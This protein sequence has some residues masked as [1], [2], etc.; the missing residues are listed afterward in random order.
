MRK[1]IVGILILIAALAVACDKKT[2][3]AEADLP[4]VEHV[5]AECPTG[6]VKLDFNGESQTFN[7]IETKDGVFWSAPM[8]A[9]VDGKK[10]TSAN[11]KKAYIG[12]CKDNGIKLYFKDAGGIYY[13]FFT[14][15][16]DGYDV[17]SNHGKGINRHGRRI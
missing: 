6:E 15:A 14:P 13:I 3:T 8:N 4:S 17:K 12:G 10:R 11:G 7:F 5:K 9:D 16:G 1:N 2:D